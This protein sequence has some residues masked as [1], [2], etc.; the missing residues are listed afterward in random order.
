MSLVF[1]EGALSKGVLQCFNCCFTALLV[2]PS[3]SVPA[4]KL[5]YTE[6]QGQTEKAYC[7]ACQGHTVWQSFKLIE[8]EVDG[9][10]TLV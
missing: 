2:K 9:S 8:Q 1:E 4:Y 3:V 5:L 10:G 6:S 7:I